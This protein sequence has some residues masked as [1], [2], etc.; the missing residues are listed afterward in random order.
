MCY[1]C[2]ASVVSCVCPHACVFCRSGSIVC[3]SIWRCFHTGTTRTSILSPSGDR[4]G[5]FL[6]SVRQWPASKTERTY[7]TLKYII[8]NSRKL[9]LTTTC[10]SHIPFSIFASFTAGVFLKQR[11]A[12][13]QIQNDRKII[14]WN[15]L[16]FCNSVMFFRLRQ[17]TAFTSLS[18]LSLKETN[19]K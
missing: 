2:C 17:L 11:N 10:I 12:I 8:Y 15:Y 3:E 6:Q 5:Q 16:C 18:C 1:V 13:E 4:K 14:C 9:L 19:A 7:K